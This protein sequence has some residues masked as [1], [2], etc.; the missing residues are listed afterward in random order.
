MV[1]V[2]F[3]GFDDLFILIN[4]PLRETKIKIKQLFLNWKKTNFQ[5]RYS[6]LFVILLFVFIVS[7]HIPNAIN[8]GDATFRQIA[9]INVLKDTAI[10]GFA[11]HIAASAHNQHLHFEESD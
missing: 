3:G 9:L 4:S 1:E 10:M 2:V 5:D 8:A 6:M 7:I 11:L